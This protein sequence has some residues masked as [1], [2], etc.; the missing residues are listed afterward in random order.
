[1][2]KK[3]VRALV[4]IAVLSSSVVAGQ[5][6]P[7]NGTTLCAI[8]ENV[9]LQLPFTATAGDVIIL[10][11]SPS[12][13]TSDV[14]RVFNN[15]TDTGGGTGLGDMVFLYSADDGP[16]PDPATYSVNAVM[17]HEP[18]T[19]YLSLN[20]NGVTYVLGVPEPA[21]FVLLGLG[22]MTM[23]RLAAGRGRRAFP[24]P[25]NR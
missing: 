4:V 16:L 17:A 22:L 8:F 11:P 15:I 23:P 19:G 2:T 1:M 6:A 21:T 5:L 18:A 3:V 7:C 25:I 13:V 24:K 12:S 9:L 20:E 14:F 10:D